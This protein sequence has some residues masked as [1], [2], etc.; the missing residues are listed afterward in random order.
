MMLE[1][2][3]HKDAHD[4]I[5]KAIEVVLKD[6]TAMTPDMGGKASTQELSQAIVDAL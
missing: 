4:Q 1:H 2:L 5:V 6:A 3:G